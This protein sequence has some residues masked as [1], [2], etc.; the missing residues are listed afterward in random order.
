MESQT[1]LVWT[2]SR[3]ELNSVSTVDLWLSLVIFPDDAELDDALR[4]GDDLEG[5]FVF[6]LL[7]E[8]GAVLKGR[9]KFC[10]VLAIGSW[11]LQLKHVEVFE[12]WRSNKMVSYLCRL[13]R[14]RAQM[15]G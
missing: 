5:G 4:D 10:L 14:T 8:E 1:A 2:K 7:L 9:N 6:G 12:S 3:V 13:A 15:E 11:E